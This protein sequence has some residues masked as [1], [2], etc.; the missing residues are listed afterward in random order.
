MANKPGGI[1]VDPIKFSQF[2]TINGDGT[3]AFNA[4]GDYSLAQEIFYIQ[5]ANDEVMNLDRLVIHILSTGALPAGSYGDLAALPS[6]IDIQ[7]TNARSVSKSILPVVIKSNVSLLHSTDLGFSLVNFTAGVDSIIAVFNCKT[8]D[9]FLILDG[10]QDHRLEILL[11]DSFV[12][13][14]DHHFIAHGHK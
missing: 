2:L 4:I 10:S 5:P 9:N 12:G 7:V 6:G 1:R 11:D 3:G 14:V 8:D 13:L